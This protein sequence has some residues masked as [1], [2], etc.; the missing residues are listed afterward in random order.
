[1]KTFKV[2]GLSLL[3]GLSW[4]CG[5]N[6]EEPANIESDVAVVL[7]ENC[8][9]C[10]GDPPQAGA[11]M[12]IEN[13]DDVLAAAPTNSDITVLEAIGDRINDEDNP[14]PPAPDDPL[15]GQPL[16]TLNDWVE[17]GAPECE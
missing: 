5:T 15:D 7:T 14:M 8:E 16:N 6:G 3:L 17:A 9:S 4:G 10:H 13:C 1:M 2:A 11:L 12:P